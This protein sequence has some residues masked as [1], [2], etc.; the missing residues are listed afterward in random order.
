MHLDMLM[1]TAADFALL[2]RGRP[3]AS[4]RWDDVREVRAE[5]DGENAFEPVRLHLNLADVS[6]FVA[7]DDAPGW[8]DFV[9]AATS[10]LPN[11]PPPNAWFTEVAGK[12][13]NVLLAL[14][15][16]S[17]RLNR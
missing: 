9:D 6:V 17:E 1:A 5:R 14:P 11:L 16:A 7:S 10:A 3:I 8:D 2:R 15:H 13:A 12:Q 4:G